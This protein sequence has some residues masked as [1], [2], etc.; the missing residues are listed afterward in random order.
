MCYQVQPNRFFCQQRISEELIFLLKWNSL[1]LFW[2]LF[3]KI[4]LKIM[5]E[6][7]RKKSGQKGPPEVIQSPLYS[8]QRK[9][10]LQRSFLSISEN[11][12]TTMRQAP[13]LCPGSLPSSQPL[14]RSVCSCSLSLGQ[15][16]SLCL[17]LM[18]GI[19]IS[20]L[21]E[22]TCYFNLQKFSPKWQRKSLI[23]IQRSHFPCFLK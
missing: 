23:K 3:I 20:C 2:T 1:C 18:A 9:T 7:S 19:C 17:S 8:E 12:R 14:G 6:N 11:T 15:A 4:K 10:G 22:N 5:E 13:R 16:P 21:Y